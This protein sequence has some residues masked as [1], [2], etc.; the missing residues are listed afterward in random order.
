M[1]RPSCARC[2]ASP[3]GKLRQLLASRLNI[4][5][6]R[7]RLVASGGKTHQTTIVELTQSMIFGL[8]QPW[9]DSSAEGHVL[10]SGQHWLPAH[11]FEGIPGQST[12]SPTLHLAVGTGAG[13]FGAGGAGAGDGFG[14]G[15]GGDGVGAGPGA[16]FA[17]AWHEEM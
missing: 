3:Q 16:P 12:A 2:S 15:A 1:H 7:T 10:R 9:N 17:H 13:G 5:V 4:Q 8:A 11:L 6:L 14:P